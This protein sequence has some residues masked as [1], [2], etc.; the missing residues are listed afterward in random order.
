MQEFTL[1]KH[2]KQRWLERVGNWP[3]AVAVQHFIDQSV[4]VQRCRDFIRPDGRPYRVLAIYWHPELD[5]VIK[6]DD[7]DRTAVTVLSRDVYKKRDDLAVPEP[8]RSNVLTSR[9]ARFRA[10]FGFNHKM[11]GETI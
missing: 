4:C 7:F 10:A 3:T 9:L 5:L 6:A 1:T 2:F 11:K 8:E